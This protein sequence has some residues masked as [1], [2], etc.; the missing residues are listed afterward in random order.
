MTVLTDQE[1][2]DR[3]ELVVEGLIKRLSGTLAEEDSKQL[4][5]TLNDDDAH[6]VPAYR[7]KPK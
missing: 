1:R 4:L 6:M 2:I 3:L 5:D 7:R